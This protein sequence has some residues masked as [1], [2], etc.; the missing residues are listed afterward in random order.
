MKIGIE[1]TANII[2]IIVIILL[3]LE[4]ESTIYPQTKIL[5]RYQI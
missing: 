5:N 1:A 3:S 2:I 4:I